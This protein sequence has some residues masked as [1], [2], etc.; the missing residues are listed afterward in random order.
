MDDET[1]RINILDKLTYEPGLRP[2][3]IIVFVK[4]GIATLSGRVRTYSEKHLAEQAAKNVRGVKA[5]AEEIIV[6]SE[7]S[8]QRN[9]MEIAE[10]VV[11][12]LEWD[13]SI[14]P[15][16]K[17]KVAVE[18]GNVELTGEVS[19]YYQKERATKCIRFLYG[20]KNIINHITV[21]PAKPAITPKEI[22]DQIVKEFHRNASI[23]AKN[24]NIEVDGSKVILKGKIR[25]WI[26]KKEAEKAAWS[27]V[28][29]TSVKDEL[30]LSFD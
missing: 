25:S 29:V 20:I 15:P 21:K 19:E 6:D 12:A 10:A 2:G 8:L 17:V 16:G 26:E 28:G 9:D 22:F 1:I 7:T 30:I 27:V 14:I 3:D 5:V 13:V 11:H 23:D 4:D 24:I 18:N